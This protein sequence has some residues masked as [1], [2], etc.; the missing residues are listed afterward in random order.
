MKPILLVLLLP[1][2]GQYN[3]PATFAGEADWPQWRGPTRNGHSPA[4]KLLKTWPEKGPKIKWTFA[5]AGIGYSTIAIVDDC[6]Y[7]LG[8]NDRS[9]FALCLN[10]QNGS[11]KWKTDFSRAGTSEDYNQGWGGGPRSTPTVNQDQVFVL[12]DI[13]V[14]ASLDKETGKVQ[15]KTDIVKD[16][17]GRIPTWGYSDSPLV[18]GNRIVVTPGEENFMLAVDR[19]T[20]KEVWKSR[21]YKEGAQYVSIM[22]DKV[23]DT[24]FYLSA[25]K[26]GIVAFDTQSGNKLFSDNATSNPTAVIPTPILFQD[27]IYHTSAYRAGNTLINLVEEGQGS[28][29]VQTAYHLT[30]KTMENQ[31]GGIVLVN[32]TIFGFSKANG[33][34]WM[35]QD[36]ETGET[37]WEEKI[38]PNK[39]GSICYADKRLYCYN[40]KDGTVFLVE[41]SRS[42][43]QQKG[44]LTL[45]K[46]TELPREKG[47]IWA[48]PVVA[49]QTLIIRDQDL[50]YAYDLAE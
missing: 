20:G 28:V 19:L 4:K 32:G 34:V 15:W 12:S 2:Y 38:R 43:W 36:L 10:L 13:G 16:H 17:N 6:V 1:L 26:A 25:S 41:P 31:H 46:Q 7:T 9:C 39:S 18:D 11:I 35:A 14:L 8:S 22:K 3:L 47:A 21:G 23:G 42:G 45:P 50:I 44:M 30:G 27:Q 5:D 37:L 33:G 29:A 48:H 40:D 49:N 24:S